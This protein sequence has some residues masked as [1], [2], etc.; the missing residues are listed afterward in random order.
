[1]AKLSKSLVKNSSKIRITLKDR[2]SELE[3][4]LSD[5]VKDAR[6]KGL[7]FTISSLSKFLKHGNM[8][9]TLAEEYIVWLCIRYGI[10]LTLLVGKPALKDKKLT[11]SI[12]PYNEEECL[13]NLI[14]LGYEGKTQTKE[15]GNRRGD[16]LPAKDVSSKSE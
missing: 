15:P 14:K 3:L 11:L 13:S 12:P 5:I 4:T 2:F 9:S 6:S 16:R 10:Q 8:K 1:M 7:N